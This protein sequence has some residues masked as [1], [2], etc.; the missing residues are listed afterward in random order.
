MGHP[1]HGRKIHPGKELPQDFPGFALMIKIAALQKVTTGI[2]PHH[3]HRHRTGVD[4]KKG[5]FTVQQF[6]L[7]FYC[8]RSW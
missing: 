5:F 2:D 6:L 3:R 8:P 7:L 4:A 1:R